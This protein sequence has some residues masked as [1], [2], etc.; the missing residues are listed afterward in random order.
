[1]KSSTVYYY[2][3]S[4][5]N[6]RVSRLKT[7]KISQGYAKTALQRKNCSIAVKRQ[8]C[9]KLALRKIAIFQ[10]DYLVLVEVRVRIRVIEFFFA[11]K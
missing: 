6:V 2:I 9:A 10:G 11:L 7:D 4:Y 3:N 5:N 1:M 8:N